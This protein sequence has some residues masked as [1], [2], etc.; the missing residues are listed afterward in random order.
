MSDPT[1]PKCEAAM[2]ADADT[3]AN[4]G[5]KVTP[6]YAPVPVEGDGG[7]F[8]CYR[9][10]RATTRLRCGKCGR[11]IC[12]SCAVIGSAGPRCPEC[13]RNK[14][15]IRAR[16]VAHEAKVAVR[17]VFRGPMR[18]IA[19]IVAFGI[20]MVLFRACRPQ[21]PR[22]DLPERQEISSEQLP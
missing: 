3:C 1:C 15:P 21:V 5:K 14:I 17:N 2:P 9:H 12:T 11:A 10:K 16:A 13:S 20:A 19:F 8:Y 4:C 18:F 22:D 7:A 6:Q